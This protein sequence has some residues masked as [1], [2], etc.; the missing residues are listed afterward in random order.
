MCDMYNSA[1]CLTLYL[2]PTG[3][4]WANFI[5]QSTI[6]H[7]ESC[8]HEVRGKPIIKS[9]QMSSHFHSGILKGCSFPVGLKWSAL[10]LLHVSHSA[11]YLA[12]CRFILI[13]QKLFFNSWYILFVPGWIEYLEQCASSIILRWSSRSFETT[14]RSFNHRTPSTSSRKHFA[15]PNTNL[16]RM[17]LILTSIRWVVMTSS[18]IVEIRAILF[19]APYETTRRLGSFKWQQ[20]VRGYTIRLL[21]WCLRLKASATTFTFPRW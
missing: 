8:S 16:L 17:W 5:R 12:I 11:M 10:T 7:I 21:Q 4:K 15:S 1:Y 6:T 3:M 19:N 20:E 18:L 9:M 13:H 14:R 2:V